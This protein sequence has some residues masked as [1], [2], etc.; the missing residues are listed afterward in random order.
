MKHNIQGVFK[1]RLSA[2][3]LALLCTALWGTAFA[4]I[5]RGYE[6]FSI[7]SG[8]IPS[9]LV[10]AGVRFF[11]AGAAVYIF[12]ALFK[13]RLFAPKPKELVKLAS[14]GFIQTF[15][16][17]ILL[18]V[19]LIFVTG[20]KS[21]I[22]TSFAAFFGVLLSPLFFKGDRLRA[23]KVF[24][25]FVGFCGILLMNLGGG[26]SV[27]EFSLVGD[28]LLIL[29]NLCGTFG[30]I[31]SKKLSESCGPIWVSA[32]QLSVGGG[33]MIAV[34]TLFSGR[35]VFSSAECFLIMAYLALISSVSVVVWTALLKYNDVSVISM[36]NLMIPVFGTAASGL[37]LGENILTACNIISLLLVAAGIVFVNIRS[38]KHE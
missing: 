25:C 15:L 20:T 35:I 3:L 5:K 38:K 1:N 10:F 28:G 21:S 26:G 2:V 9:T 4:A 30:N 37:V 12:H 19:A 31:F 34:G 13:R 6:I 32:T 27:G 36:F 11:S 17:Y 29:S 7:E 22:Y 14:L 33:L 23:G 16:Q 18:Y 8:D 24:G